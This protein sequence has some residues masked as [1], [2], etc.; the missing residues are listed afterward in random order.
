MDVPEPLGGER[1]RKGLVRIY[2]PSTRARMSRITHRVNG[3]SGFR[4]WAGDA[5]M[6][7]PVED[8]RSSMSRAIASPLDD[9]AFA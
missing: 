9:S 5:S 8:K 7:L 6:K 3:G 1:K 4:S 2:N